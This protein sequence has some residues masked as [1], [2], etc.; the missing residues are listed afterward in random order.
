MSQSLTCFKYVIIG[1]YFVLIVVGKK[2]Y[3]R[4]KIVLVL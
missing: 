1:M 3:L 4:K 2:E